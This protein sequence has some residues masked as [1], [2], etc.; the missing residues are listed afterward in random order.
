[1]A[2]PRAA[3]RLI[4][5]LA[6]VNLEG[7]PTI[8]D[9]KQRARPTGHALLAL[10]FA[11]SFAGTIG[12][13]NGRGY[14]GPE[15]PDGEIATVYCVV[16]PFGSK[17]FAVQIEKIE[18]ERSFH[19]WSGPDGIVTLL[20]GRY[21]LRVSAANRPKDLLMR[22]ADAF[23][24]QHRRTFQLEVRAGHEYEID[25]DRA[26]AFYTVTAFAREQ[27]RNPPPRGTGAARC[28]LTPTR[29]DRLRCLATFEQGSEPSPAGRQ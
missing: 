18:G 25:F 4:G 19:G 9:R 21:E 15:R 16:W 28:E 14:P 5:S 24:D 13:A 17:R 20:P 12:C 8:R 6:V 3:D 11:F 27:S 29:L 10:A 7:T 23:S 22:V 2:G 1:M 26:G